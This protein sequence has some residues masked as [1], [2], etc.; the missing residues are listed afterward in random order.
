M[1]G[2]KD[3][4][5]Y[6]HGSRVTKYVEFFPIKITPLGANKVL[7]EEV[8]EGIIHA[9]IADASGWVYEMFDDIR[10]WSLYEVDN[11]QVV[12]VRCHGIPAYAWDYDFFR[13]LGR[14]FGEL[15]GVDEYTRKQ[16]S[17]DVARLLTR[18]KG[19]NVFNMVVHTTI[20]NSKFHVKM[21]EEWCGPMHWSG[22]TKANEDVI[23]IESADC[24]TSSDSDDGPPLF[25]M[26]ED[27]SEW[28]ESEFS[29]KDEKTPTLKTSVRPVVHAR[30]GT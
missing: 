15:L 9:L 19:Y 21:V 24:D 13:A 26:E 6:S 11:E 2:G 18:T 3:T 5:V 10:R 12:W 23:G 22:L 25:P 16:S 17:M 7:M 14:K 1:W 8:E 27:N 20:N 4:R 28:L 30:L 29:G